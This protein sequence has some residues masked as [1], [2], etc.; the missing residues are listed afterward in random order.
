MVSFFHDNYVR[1]N[2]M[3]PERFNSSDS[4]RFDSFGR[5]LS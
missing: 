5:G 1:R 2:L 3:A 4:E